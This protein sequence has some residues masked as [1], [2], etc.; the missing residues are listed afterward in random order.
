[1]SSENVTMMDDDTSP[2]TATECLSSLSSSSLLAYSSSTTN[3]RTPSISTTTSNKRRLMLVIEGYDFQLKNFNKHRTIKF[4][5]CANR[6][7]HVLVHTTLENQFFRYGGKLSSHTHLPNPSASEVWNLREAM[8][9][10]AENE[11]T[12]LQNIAEQKVRQALLTAEALVKLPRIN[13]LGHNLVHHR[14]KTTPPIPQSSSF[15]IPESYTNDYCNKARLLLYDSDD[16]KYQLNQSGHIRSEGRILVW[17]SDIQLNLLFNSQKLHID[18]T[19]STSPPHFEQ[20]FIIQAF[21]QGS[22]KLTL[23][24]YFLLYGTL[25]EIGVPVLYAVLP[26]RKASTYIHLFTILFDHAKRLNKKCDPKIVMT[27]FEPGL[28]KAI[29]LEAIYRNVQSLGLASVYLDNLMIRSVIRRIMALALVP[30]KF[31][32][33]L[34]DNLGDDLSQSE[35]DELAPLFKYFTNYWLQPTSM[36]NVF[37][38][39]DKTNNFSE[40]MLK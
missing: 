13:N 4:W 28:T 21:L 30:A 8:R 24:H 15:F 20:V 5:R 27:D 23:F 37:D 40:D 14:R 12:A 33:T 2:S 26:D 38:I 39:P 29:S 36:W 22:C 11:T 16:P 17:S 35:L 34:F 25:I 1:M 18:G 19:F 7:C 32:S 9:K 10:R 3:S 31:I 6:S